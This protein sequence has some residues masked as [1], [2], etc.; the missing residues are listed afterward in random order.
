MRVLSLLTLL[1]LAGLLVT[2]LAFSQAI[3]DTLFASTNLTGFA[4]PMGL[5]AAD[6]DGDLDIDLAV[7]NFGHDEIIIV[8]N[9]GLGNF[10]IADQIAV[11]F[12]PWHIISADFNGDTHA[13]LAVTYDADTNLI[14]VVLNDGIGGFA[15]PVNYTVG[16]NHA[17][18]ICVSD[19][20]NDT[21]LDL[22]TVNQT[23]CSY[24]L[25]AGAGDGT[26]AA[27]VGGLIGY[28]AD[29][30]CGK[31][32]LYEDTNADLVFA[33]QY[34]NQI[35]L[36]LGNGSGIF[37]TT[38]T[39]AA[40]TN[41]TELIISDLDGDINH[42]NDVVVVNS[43]VNRV[44]ILRNPDNSQNMS[45]ANYYTVGQYPVAVRAA[46]FNNDDLQDL[47][48]A[49]YG[50]NDMY[51]LLQ[52]GALAY[53]SPLDHDVPG[54]PCDIATGDFDDDNDIDCAV[55]SF[56]G[57]SVS[58][59]LNNLNSPTAIGDDPE[60]PN[61]PGQFSLEPNYPNPFNPATEISF[62]LPQ[63]LAVTLEIFNLAGQR[64]TTLIDRDMPAGD[65]VIPWDGTDSG[66]AR[67]STG[68]YFYRLT[69]GDFVE[70]RKML[71]LK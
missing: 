37:P 1:C 28:C 34:N 71:L 17:K 26:F 69:A 59:L 7:A 41:P 30:I 8:E 46:D 62:S 55:V 49:N 5:C 18:D 22:A 14:T 61:V 54:M 57:N 29:A 39:Y 68:V 43:S 10:S 9:D 47:V 63:Q 36:R 19:F 48:V 44:T 45:I 66:G 15:A 53:S 56:S 31:A 11:I 65:Y 70:S 58:I 42:T 21:Y 2:G 50:S 20:N 32:V 6:F 67:V 52:T 24:S 60:T 38:K 64:V 25:L 13:D 40:G 23:G 35:V 12:S 33:D 4:S 51:I 3:P 27:A 16:G